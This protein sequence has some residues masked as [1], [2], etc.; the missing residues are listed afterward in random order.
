[1]CHIGFIALLKWFKKIE[2][3]GRLS[4]FFPLLLTQHDAYLVWHEYYFFTFLQDTII[5]FQELKKRYP[6]NLRSLKTTFLFGI[7]KYGSFA[8]RIM[9]VLNKD[10]C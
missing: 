5:L 1:M 6:L 7:E 4:Y 10:N 3:T 9:L 8:S 2:M